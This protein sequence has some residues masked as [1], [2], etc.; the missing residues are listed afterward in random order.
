[1]KKIQTLFFGLILVHASAASAVMKKINIPKGCIPAQN[2]TWSCGPNAAGRMLQYFH[3]LNDNLE[4]LSKSVENDYEK[5]K[6][7]FPKSFN[8]EKLKELS[9]EEINCSSIGPNP[10]A[11]A[12]HMN[13]H[14][15][16]SL[17]EVVTNPQVRDLAIAEILNNRPVI[18]LTKVGEFLAVDRIP[19]RLADL[20]RNAGGKDILLPEMHYILL[21]GYDEEAHLFSYVDSTGREETVSYDDLGQAWNW[22]VVIPEPQNRLL[23]TGLMMFGPQLEQEGFGRLQDLVN[24]VGNTMITVKSAAPVIPAAAQQAQVPAAAQMDP[25]LLLGMFFQFIS[26]PNQ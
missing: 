15:T 14:S 17:F 4:L 10:Q 3:H 26:K 12:V 7:S 6:K 22:E 1:M 9:G 11:L 5:F 25:S 20:V 16:S 2:D 8:A 24:V 21:N 19:P 23:R 18:A 13:A